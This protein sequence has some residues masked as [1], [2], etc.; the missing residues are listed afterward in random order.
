MGLDMYAMTTK[1]ILWKPVDFPIL[2]Q[3]RELF[4]WRKHPNLFGAMCNLYYEKDGR[5]EDFNVATLH[6]SARDLD[7]LEHLISAR[8]LPYTTGF[9]F[10]ASS[11]NR[12]E[13]DRDLAFVA[14]ARAAIAER[15]NVYFYAWW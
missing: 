6:L 3:D 14:K 12:A 10:G 13:R 1:R 15:L 9:F 11:N 7:R 2:D 5:N 8:R 4:T